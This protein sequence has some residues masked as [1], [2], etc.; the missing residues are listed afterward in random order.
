MRREVLKFALAGSLA[1]LFCG[2]VAA[3]TREIAEWQ[4]T[5]LTF[6]QS[7][8]NQLSYDTYRDPYDELQ[9][10]PYNLLFSNIGRYPNLSPWQGQEGSYTHYF[11]ALI[12]NNGRS[13]VDNNADAIQGALVRRETPRL[14][15]GVAGAF[16]AGTDNSSDSVGTTN[17]R[18]TDEVAGFELRGGAALQLG[19][20]RVFG[21]GLTVTSAM[22][23]TTEASFE[24]G[25]G[26]FF[27][28]DEFAHTVFTVDAGLRTFLT[29]TSSWEA[30]VIVGLG[31]AEQNEFSE[32]IDDTGAVNDRFYATHYDIDHMSIGLWGGYNR[33]HDNRFGEIEFRGGIERAQRELGNTD[34]SFSETLGV[35][36][37]LA[38]LLGQDS[39]SA[40]RLHFSAKSIFRAGETEM[41]TGASLSHGMLDGATQIDVSGTVINEEIDDSQTALGLTVGLRQPLFRDKLRF[42]VSGHADFIDQE[43][44][45]IFDTV[46]DGDDSTISSAQY[47]VGLEGVLANVV[48]DIAWLFGEEAPV[49]PVGIGLPSGSRRSVE[50]DRLVFSAAISW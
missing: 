14:S 29:S 44:A 28:A 22:D 49:T 32:T 34:L 15:W 23:E 5:Q 25:V 35:P 1:A 2:G 21:A 50:L 9:T 45:T 24:P 40:T 13:N 7:V 39:I 4:P 48:F 42:I 47:A 38:T 41:F 31:S 17:F 46:T 26:G 11:N 6:G 3:A 19:E 36:T 30:Q 10:R 8:L 37:P 16:L 18:D 43:T 12:G 33:L 20:S 27:G